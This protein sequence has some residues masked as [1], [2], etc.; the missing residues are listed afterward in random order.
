MTD[1]KAIK[2]KT[3]LSLASDLGNAEGEGEIWFN[4][5]SGDFKTIVAAGAWATAED[6][7]ANLGYMAAGGS[8]PAGWGAGGYTQASA[9]VVTCNEYDGTDWTAGG[10]LNSARATR[11]NAGT[12]TAALIAT[13][14]NY[15][16]TTRKF[17]A[18][19]E[20]NGSSWAEGNDYP[21][22]MSGAAGTGTQTA[23]LGMGGNSAAPADNTTETYE[24][25]GSSWTDT[26][27]LN[28]GRARFVSAGTQTAGLALGGDPNP[29]EDNSESYDGSSW[30]EVNNLNSGRSHFGGG[31]IQTDAICF[32]S[33]ESPEQKYTETYDGTS[34]SAA[35]VM[36]TSRY[37]CGGIPQ[38][39]TAASAGAAAIGDATAPGMKDD[40]EEWSFGVTTGPGAM[41]VKVITD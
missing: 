21:V 14:D 33:Q 8:V 27:D 23:G 10:D 7:P 22:A 30:T 41:N 12:Q 1:Y 18:S 16:G 19:E 2:G 9:S 13:G 34:W 17:T 40:V 28:T 3:V 5:T 4:T 39:G 32:G 36:N 38:G 11:V 25:D 35:A 6:Y 20:Y 26:A 37:A 24:Y 15:P 31:G 29:I